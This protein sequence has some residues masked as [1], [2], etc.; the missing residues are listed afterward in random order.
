V[1]P[2]LAAGPPVRCTTSARLGECHQWL[3]CLGVPLASAALRLPLDSRQCPHPSVAWKYVAPA[4]P[5]ICPAAADRHAFS[6]EPP[7][8]PLPPALRVVDEISPLI[9]KLGAV[10]QLFSFPLLPAPQ[11]SASP[12]LMT[13]DRG[14]EP[15]LYCPLPLPLRASGS[16]GVSTGFHTSTRGLGSPSVASEP[17]SFLGPQ[18]HPAHRVRPLTVS[19]P[20]P[21]PSAPFPLPPPPEPPGPPLSY[22]ILYHPGFLER[23][24]RGL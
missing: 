3:R 1:C 9:S 16:M 18:M 6:S 14:T 19:C 17:W 23:T 4:W 12:L 15:I 11:W 7:P 10:C 8:P 5:F 2:L 20:W 21:I 24:R 22:S 13:H